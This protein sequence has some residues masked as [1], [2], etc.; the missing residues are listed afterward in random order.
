MCKVKCPECGC[1]F[2]FTRQCNK[3]PWTAAEDEQI[4]K[5]Y[6]AERKTL[7]QIA[8]EMNRTQDAVRNRLYSLRG[9]GK[10]AGVAAVVH[11]TAKDYDDMRAAKR[12]AKEAK[13]DLK[14]VTSALKKISSLLADGGFIR[15]FD[16]EFVI[17]NKTALQEA[18]YIAQDC[19]KGE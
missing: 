14:R 18:L 6:Q 12:T 8:E 10:P 7:S 15:D 11:L 4:L 1:E 13:R 3:G 2:D 5:A 17:T 9:A 16:E 19:L